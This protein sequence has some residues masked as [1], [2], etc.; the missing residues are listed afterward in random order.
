VSGARAVSSAVVIGDDLIRFTFTDFQGNSVSAPLS[1]E[2]AEA[3]ITMLVSFVS[4]EGRTRLRVV[5]EEL[6]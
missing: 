4:S 6:P 5:L 1:R 3:Y 2:Q